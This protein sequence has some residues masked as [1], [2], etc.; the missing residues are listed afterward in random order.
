[1]CWAMWDVEH[2]LA[3]ASLKTYKPTQMIRDTKFGR[4]HKQ[5]WNKKW[6]WRSAHKWS[7]FWFWSLIWPWRSLSIILQTN[8]DLNQGLFHLWSKFD[9]PSLN[10]WWLMSY[11]MDKLKIDGQTQAHTH[12]GKD[13]T[14]RPKLASGKN[15]IGHVWTITTKNF[16]L[17]TIT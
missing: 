9:D 1:M 6:N 13:N 15:H 8:R 3:M 16:K 7:K 12:T 10:S 4:K 17:N 14:R 11:H 5:H 2:S